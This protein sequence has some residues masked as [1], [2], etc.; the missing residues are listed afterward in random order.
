M[1][2]I[3]DNQ[4][5]LPVVGPVQPVFGQLDIERIAADAD[6][7]RTPA[8]QRIHQG[9]VEMR[10]APGV[11]HAQDIVFHTTIQHCAVILEAVVFHLQEPPAQDIVQTGRQEQQDRTGQENLGQ[12]PFHQNWK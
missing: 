6:A 7:E 4:G 9:R 12:E 8:R 5:R 3:L 2:D 11:A 10:L 1:V